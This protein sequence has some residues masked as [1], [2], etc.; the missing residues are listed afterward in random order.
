MLSWCLFDWANSP[1]PTVVVTFVFS[2][3]FAKLV[4]G[5]EIEGTFLWGQ[6]IA[7]AG[8]LVGIFGPLLGAIADQGGRRKPWITGFSLACILA[9]AALYFVTP[10]RA[11]I[12]LA[13]IAV[14]VA[15]LCFEF[16]TIFYNATLPS[17]A[18]PDRIGRVSG[19]GWGTGYV[20]AIFCLA[21]VLFGLIQNPAPPFGLDPEKAENIRA[22]VLV[23]AGWWIFFG[24]PFLVFMPDG[25]KTGMSVRDAIK[26]GT[27][28]LGTTLRNLGHYRNIS[29]FLLARM[30]YADGLAT[31]FQFGGLYAAGTF[32]MSFAEI[33]QFGM[34]MNVTAGF[35]AFCFAWLDDRTGSKI[36]IVIALVGLILFGMAVLLAESSFWFWIFGL[37]LS[38]F[39]GPAQAASRTLLTRLAP[40]GMETEMFGLYALSG[41]STSFLGPLLFGWFTLMFDS[42]R[43]GMAIILVFWIAGL[44]LLTLVREERSTARDSAGEPR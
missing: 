40:Q 32:G 35:G 10:D 18:S 43:A 27:T 26:R 4:V 42:Q 33:I 19:W 9:T 5:N 20:G 22:T 21:L 44:V 41:K 24:W 12:P 14:A 34:A 37:S 6:T 7:I 16:A 11:A 31:L 29:V 23:V 2:A 15:T 38:L 8:F 17:V 28:N 39:I 3:Y 25:K 30:L 13:L 1:Q 36:T